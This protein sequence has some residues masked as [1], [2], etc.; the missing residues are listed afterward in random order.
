MAAL[1]RTALTL[2]TAREIEDLLQKHLGERLPSGIAC[3]VG[4]S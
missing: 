1:A 4:K 3:P 2:A